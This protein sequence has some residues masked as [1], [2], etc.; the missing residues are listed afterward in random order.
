MCDST[1]DEHPLYISVISVIS[2]TY[3][4]IYI[5]ALC[6]IKHKMDNKTTYDPNKYT[7]DPEHPEFVCPVCDYELHNRGEL[8]DHMDE[9]HEREDLARAMA[10]LL[11]HNWKMEQ[12]I[13][14]LT[15]KQ[16][17]EII[18]EDTN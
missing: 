8:L 2:A 10:L 6:N 12:S 7:P 17:Y 1:L 18:K 9:R 5:I 3:I 13:R 15:G 4:R 11:S 16:A 14:K